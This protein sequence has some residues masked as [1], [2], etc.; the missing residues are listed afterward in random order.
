MQDVYVDL[1]V[2]VLLLFFFF[3]LSGSLTV[4]CTDLTYKCK[5]N[6]CISK[7]NPEC[8]SVPDCS[9]KSDE[10]N[11]GTTFKT[12]LTSKPFFFVVVGRV[13]QSNRF[14]TSTCFTTSCNRFLLL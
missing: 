7:T 12:R 8:D 14:F 1:N 2:F 10:S 11:C 13:V 4:P 5:D 6:T 3:F 9:D